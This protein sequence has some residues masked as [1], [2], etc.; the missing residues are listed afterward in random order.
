LPFVIDE[1]DRAIFVEN[2]DATLT[3]TLETLAI[4]GVPEDTDGGVPPCSIYQF[5]IS[6]STATAVSGPSCHVLESTQTFKSGAFTVSGN[7]ATIT[8]L[9]DVSPDPGTTVVASTTTLSETCSRG[10]ESDADAAS[11]ASTD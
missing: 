3:M 7:N 6:G 10:P 2:P 9:T 4:R 11:E 1:T 5:A 8:L